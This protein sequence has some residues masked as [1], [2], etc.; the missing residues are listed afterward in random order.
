ME[1]R[2]YVL[3]ILVT[4]KDEEQRTLTPYDNHDTAIRKYHEAFN[5]IGGGP[6]FISA[7]ILDRYLNVDPAYRSYWEQQG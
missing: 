3:Q 4:S 7:E 6:K 1:E 2:W 5:T